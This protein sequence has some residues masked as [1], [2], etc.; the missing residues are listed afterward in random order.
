MTEHIRSSAWC[1]CLVRPMIVTEKLGCPLSG[2]ALS[3]TQALTQGIRGQLR[4]ACGT[5]FAWFREEVGHVEA[6]TRRRLGSDSLFLPARFH[7]FE[8]KVLTTKICRYSSAIG[9]KRLSSKSGES[10]GS[11][12][13]PPGNDGTGGSNQLS[14]ERIL[15]SPELRFESVRW[16]RNKPT[17]LFSSPIYARQPT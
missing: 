12:A 15:I 16:T 6:G 4:S 7:S 3:E 11:R 17:D 8:S 5:S 9:V 14:D 2:N 13:R 1:C 10:W